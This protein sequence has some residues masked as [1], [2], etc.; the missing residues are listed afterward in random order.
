[1]ACGSTKMAA[2]AITATVARE[3]MSAQM[4]FK[5][6]LFNNCPTQ[7]FQAKE[8][9]AATEYVT[10]PGAAEDGVDAGEGD[11]EEG[12]GEGEAEL[13]VLA[14]GACQTEVLRGCRCCAFGLG[15]RRCPLKYTCIKIARIGG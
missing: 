13:D 11:R 3:P 8:A 9:E 10:E 15:S 14:R 6:T 5:R 2:I 12:D 7:G 1:M 4:S